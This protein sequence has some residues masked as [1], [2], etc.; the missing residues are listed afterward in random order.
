MVRFGVL[1]HAVGLRPAHVFRPPAQRQLVA[2]AGIIVRYM[3]G[4]LGPIA[5]GTGV[6]IM[7]HRICGWVPGKAGEHRDRP[8]Q[9]PVATDRLLHEKVVTVRDPFDFVVQEGI[10]VGTQTVDVGAA[11]FEYR[12]AVPVVKERV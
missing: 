2:N 9:R 3:I 8:S 4:T 11:V 5:R 7:R 10:E 1:A 6:D 12:A